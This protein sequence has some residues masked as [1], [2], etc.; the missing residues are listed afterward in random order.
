VAASSHGLSAKSVVSFLL[1]VDATI[2]LIAGGHALIGAPSYTIEQLFSLDNEPTIPG[3]Y[4]SIKL[5]LLAVLLAALG[6]SIGPASRRDKGLL[7]AAFVFFVMSC[8]EAAAVHERV[9][10]MIGNRFL[11]NLTADNIV[12]AKVVLGLAGLGVASAATMLVIRTLRQLSCG[13]AAFGLGFLLLASGAVGVD[14]LQEFFPSSGVE[15]ALG[16]ILEEAL[17]TI[18]VTIMVFGASQ[19]L[20]SAPAIIYLG[21]R[22]YSKSACDRGAS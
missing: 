1:F 18:G 14:L 8:D 20:A 22:L 21:G 5:L 9:Q 6:N 10:A 13:R 3:W 19:A 12:S 11:A 15:A 7:A 17:E 2:L 16:K 4:A